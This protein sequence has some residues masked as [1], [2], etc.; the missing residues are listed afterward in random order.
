MLIK[1]I[2]LESFRN[3]QSEKIELNNNINVF[4]GNN[5]QGK[6]NILEALYFSAL[7]RSF[8]TFKE[9]E[10]IMFNKNIAKIKI[11][12]EKKGRE[13]LIEIELNKNS[14]K[15]IRLNK[16]KLNK[17]SELIGNLNIVIFSPDDIIILKQ[18]PA[19]RRK[20]LDILI[21]QLKPNYVHILAEYNKVLDQR[22][23]MLKSRNTETIEIWDEQLATFAEKIYDYRKTYIEKLNDRIKELERQIV[24]IVEET[25]K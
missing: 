9:N 13:N 6:T 25:E 3:Y 20:F 1:N 15:V 22:N 24:R 16:I 4:F 18:A 2:Y 21:S 7:G 11:E 10:L 19:L 17:N 8:R 12:Y 14:K 23:A 5:A